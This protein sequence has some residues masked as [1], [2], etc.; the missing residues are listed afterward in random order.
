MLLFEFKYLHITDTLLH[1]SLPDSKY[2][3]NISQKNQY[4][5]KDALL[6]FKL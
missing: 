5:N 3:G 6:T 2:N 4:I 1:K